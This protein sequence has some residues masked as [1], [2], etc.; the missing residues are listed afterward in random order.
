MAS[1]SVAGHSGEIMAAQPVDTDTTAAPASLLG[2][3]APEVGSSTKETQHMDIA[4]E[5]E[6]SLGLPASPEKDSKHPF[7]AQG[8]MGNTPASSPSSQQK[9]STTGRTVKEYHPVLQR[10]ATP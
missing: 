9:N 7:G 1:D 10:N 8:R 4:S 6:G 3:M 2:A 5:S